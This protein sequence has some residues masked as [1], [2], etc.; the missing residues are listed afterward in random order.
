MVYG[1]GGYSRGFAVVANEVGKLAEHAKTATKE[2]AGLIR[3]LQKTVREAITVMEDGTHEAEHGA[4][5][6]AEAREAL[7]I[8]LKTVETV[9]H[10]VGEIAAAVQHMNVSSGE[11]VKAMERVS[12]IVEKNTAAT[13]EMAANSSELT[14]AVENIASISEENS[15]AV[16]QVS[17]STE[18]VLA[19]VEQV[20]SSATALMQ[21]ARNLQNVV[22]QF[23]LK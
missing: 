5:Q 15:A 3:D 8:I 21:M 7:S 11:L 19:Q 18:E 14:R 13:E 12:S 2:V 4:A 20:S 16:E 6:A 9:S 22:A 10:Q 1:L 23:T 17:A